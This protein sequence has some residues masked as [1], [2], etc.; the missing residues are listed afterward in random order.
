[1]WVGCFFFLCV[2]E[3][4]RDRERQGERKRTKLREDYVRRCQSDPGVR[5]WVQT[6]QKHRE[7]QGEAIMEAGHCLFHDDF[8]RIFSFSHIL[9]TANFHTGNRK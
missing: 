3:R 5:P 1:M 7:A 2:Y 4:D 9:S 6:L 8:L